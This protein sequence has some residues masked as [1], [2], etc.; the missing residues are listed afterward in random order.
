ML[1]IHVGYKI[2]SFKIFKNSSILAIS[3]TYDIL[4]TDYENYAVF[5]S[6]ESDY[7]VFIM[8]RKTLIEKE[9]LR[10]ALMELVEQGLTNFYLIPT[11]QDCPLFNF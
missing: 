3:K 8:S 5:Y 7:H 9:Y 2:K 6:C 1:H 11:L 4:E 10:L